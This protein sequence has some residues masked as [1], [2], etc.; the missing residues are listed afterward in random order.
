MSQDVVA[1]PDQSKSLHLLWT[2][3]LSTLK[4][5]ESYSRGGIGSKETNF[6][7][8]S[9]NDSHSLVDRN[10]GE[11][12]CQTSKQTRSCGNCLILMVEKS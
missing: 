10:W 11:T 8:T 9:F 3:M 4:G 2:E 1:A 7:S 6:V 12:N 5:L